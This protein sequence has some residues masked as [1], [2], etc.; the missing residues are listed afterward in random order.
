MLFYFAIFISSFI[1]SHPLKAQTPPRPEIDLNDF[2][3]DLTQESDQTIDYSQLFDRLQDFLQNPIDLNKTDR[4]ELASLF[5]LNE[6]QLN[7][8]FQYRGKFGNLLSVYELQSIPEFDLNTIYRLLPFVNATDVGINVGGQNLFQRIAHE[9]NSWVMVRYQQ[10][11]EPQVGY[12]TVISGQDTFVSKDPYQGDQFKLY[13]RVSISHTK[14]FS[15]G[16]V[17]EKDAGEAFAWNPD[18]SRYGMDYYSGHFQLY[19]KGKFKTIA[20]GDYQLQFGQG[21]VMNTGFT[22]GKGA[23]TITTARKPG[24][25][26]RPYSSVIEGGFLRGGAVTYS[27]LKFFDISAYYSWLNV[28]A[29]IKTVKDSLNQE[30]AFI[31]RFEEQ[32]F[33]RTKNELL[34]RNTVI[35]QTMGSHASYN[36][37]SG[38]WQAGATWTRTNYMDSDSL[39][40]V[41]FKKSPY[42][43]NYFEFT[44]NTNEVFGADF[45]IIWRNFN[46]FGE[47]ARSDSGGTGQIYGLIASLSK[48]VEFAYVYR[49]YSKDFHSIFGNPF[50]ESSRPI[51]EKGTYWGIKITPNKRWVWSCYFDIFDF[52]WLKYQIDGPSGGKEFLTKITYTPSKHN[53]VY[54]QFKYEN[55]LN[56]T[57]DELAYLDYL[58]PA[59]KN[60]YRLHYN[61]KLPGSPENQISMASRIELNDYSRLFSVTTYGYMLVQDFNFEINRFTFGTRCALFDIPDFNNRIYSYEK[62]VLYAFSTP[63]VSGT[64]LRTYFLLRTRIIKNLD[65][66]GRYALFSYRDRKIVGSGNELSAGNNRSEIILQLRYKF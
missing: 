31:S 13:S 8:F 53:N 5:I 37:P 21:L 1:I 22:M 19:N 11:I 57:S 24:S 41:N 18:S 32:G 38:L 23:E 62:N 54:F 39:K 9:D 6:S 50:A 42:P 16:L 59:I 65:F 49:N 45:T 51:N 48:Q 27:L 20:L 58:S 60:S 56:N 10:L 3:E 34:S 25:G 26:I 55:K 33:H 15:L 44:G 14:D 2:I 36:A 63:T 43:Y 40:P 17:A 30:E 64:G 4:D 66:W 61:Y 35:T 28:D 46:F 47:A 12:E 52:P 29:D 7:S